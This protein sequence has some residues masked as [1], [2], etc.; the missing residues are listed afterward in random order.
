MDMNRGMTDYG[1]SNSLLWTQ[2][3]N[4][5]VYCNTHQFCSLTHYLGDACRTSRGAER[6]LVWTWA[7]M[8]RVLRCYNV[9]LSDLGLEF[10]MISFYP[11]SL[12]CE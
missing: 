4:T 8:G 1:D 5:W 10:M 3:L 11:Y 6:R 9:N 12:S 2:Q 7:L